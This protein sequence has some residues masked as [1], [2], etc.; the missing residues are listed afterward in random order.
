MRRGPTPTL[1]L[2]LMMPAPLLTPLLTLVLAR[3]FVTVFVPARTE[4]PMRPAQL[5]PPPAPETLSVRAAVRV[6]PIGGL[7]RPSRG[8]PSRFWRVPPPMPCGPKTPGQRFLQ[9]V[10]RQVRLS[11]MSAAPRGP[12]RAML[13]RRP[14]MPPLVLLRPMPVSQAVVPLVGVAAIRSQ[15]TL[16]QPS[17]MSARFVKVSRVQMSQAKGSAMRPHTSSA[18]KLVPP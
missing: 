13:V 5:L 12:A 4:S 11:S 15:P 9:R 17:R 2:L 18:P 1:V 16:R 8:K 14:A 10:G 3:A 6:A 7:G